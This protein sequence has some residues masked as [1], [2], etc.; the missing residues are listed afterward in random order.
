M[1]RRR[2]TISAG[3]RRGWSACLRTGPRW[4]AFQAYGLTRAQRPN[5]QPPGNACPCRP[6]H[7]LGHGSPLRAATPTKR[8]AAQNM[9]A[10]ADQVTLTGHERGPGGPSTACDRIRCLWCR[11]FGVR[12]WLQRL[13]CRRLRHQNGRVGAIGWFLRGRPIAALTGS[14]GDPRE[15]SWCPSAVAGWW[16]LGVSL[17]FQLSGVGDEFGDSGVDVIERAGEGCEGGDGGF[18]SVVGGGPVPSRS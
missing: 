3:H 8:P 7:R 4:R 11:R 17:F 10:P 13:R 18:L 15:V 14:V 2:W 6:D 16:P 1:G 5:Q 12:F 9:C